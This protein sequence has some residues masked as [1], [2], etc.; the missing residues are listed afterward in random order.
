MG[1]ITYWSIL[2]ALF[3]LTAQ[4]IQLHREKRAK[5]E[6]GGQDNP[7]ENEQSTASAKNETSKV[8][9]AAEKKTTLQSRERSLT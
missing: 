5:A 1:T 7:A 9:I 3:L 4:M 6:S 2:A 8:S